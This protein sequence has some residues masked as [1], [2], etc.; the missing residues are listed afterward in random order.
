MENG[1]VELRNEWSSRKV[2]EWSC[3]RLWC[4]AIKMCVSLMVCGLGKYLV[5]LA[6][7]APPPRYRGMAC[8]RLS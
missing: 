2:Y 5:G 1:F 4:F 7:E 3:C 6:S 8:G